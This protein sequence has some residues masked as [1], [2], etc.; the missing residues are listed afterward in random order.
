MRDNLGIICEIPAERS[1]LLEK[2]RTANRT[3]LF[4]TEILCPIM[5]RDVE[6]S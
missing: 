2:R 5:F 6:R 4:V 1:V 3:S